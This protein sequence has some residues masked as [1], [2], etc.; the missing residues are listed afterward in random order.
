MKRFLGIIIGIMFA[1]SL[2]ATTQAAVT[3]TV[4]VTVLVRYLSVTVTAGDP[5]DFGI[6]DLSSQTV[7]TAD[8]DIQNDGNA[9]EDFQLQITTSPAN[10]SVE[11][12]A[13]TA[14]NQDEYQLYAMFDADG[15]LAAV[16][17]AAGDY[18]A[19]DLILESGT[20]QGDVNFDSGDDDAN[21]VAAAATVNMWM[22]F[23]APPS[24]SA[25][26][27]QQTIVITVTAVAA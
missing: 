13:A 7:A 12:A 11:E 24:L 22:M 9:A 6:V 15:L 4:T 5:Y 21:D 2:V 19:G 10:L 25:G 26:H 1:F 14:D 3:D 23:G 20:R 17:I 27:P 18:D 16:A 8:V